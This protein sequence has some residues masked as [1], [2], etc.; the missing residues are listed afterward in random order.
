MWNT[1]KIGGWEVY[2]MMTENNKKM[3]NAVTMNDD[4]TAA[5]KTLDD[6]LNKVKYKAFGKVKF[7][8]CVKTSK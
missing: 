6:E 1:N 7:Q 5:M 2:R 8:N 3:E 4:P